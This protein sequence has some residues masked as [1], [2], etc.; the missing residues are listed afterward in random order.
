MVGLVPIFPAFF[1][2]YNLDALWSGAQ[3]Y[4]VSW[5]AL[6]F[7]AWPTALAL[8]IV[9]V[10]LIVAIRWIVL[11]RVREGSYSIHSFSISANGS[12]ASRPR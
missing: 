8:T 1:V 6:P 11:P 3:D 5:S 4:S 10:A 2:L 7:F 9:S 12:W